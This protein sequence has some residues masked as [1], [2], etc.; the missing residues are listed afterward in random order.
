MAPTTP[1]LID[2]VTGT[3][4]PPPGDR[5]GAPV[6]PQVPPTALPAPAT[7]LPALLARHAE[8]TPNAL[9]VVDG[10]TT[11]TYGGLLHAGHAL[12]AYLR[13]HEVAR[14][15]RVALL[16]TR[17]ARTVVAQLG[18]WLAGAVCVPLDAAHPGRAPRP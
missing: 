17:S 7:T 9:A 18:L 6:P 12:A 13:D 15:D 8:L 4:A 14:G 5:A 1:Q 2:P 16:T 3:P 10:D 11:L